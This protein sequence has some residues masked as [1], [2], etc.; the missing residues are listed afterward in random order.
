MFICICSY[1]DHSKKIAS[2][3]L[4]SFSA[5]EVSSELKIKESSIEVNSQLSF[6]A[7]ILA[8]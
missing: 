4:S 3:F 7:S 1:V 8:S 5:S 6:K 2:K